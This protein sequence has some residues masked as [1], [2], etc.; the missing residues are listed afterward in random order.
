MFK[1]KTA[2]A[3]IAVACSMQAH[4]EEKPYPT[5]QCINHLVHEARLA[6]IADKVALSHTADTSAVMLELDR[7]VAVPEHGA[8]ELWSKLRQFCFDLGGAFRQEAVTPERAALAT[9]LFDLHQSLIE[10]LRAGRI[11]YGEF[12]LRRVELYLVATSVEEQILERSEQMPVGHT[13]I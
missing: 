3:A 13:G 6:T 10:E 1:T 5:N 11:T 8:L 9:R 4:A 12:N 7:P 2:L